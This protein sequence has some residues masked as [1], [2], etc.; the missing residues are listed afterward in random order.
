MV[1]YQ[2][3]YRIDRVNQPAKLTAQTFQRMTFK[4]RTKRSLTSVTIPKLRTEGLR[5]Y[6]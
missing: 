5:N 3:V 2:R 1:Q 6:C 4:N